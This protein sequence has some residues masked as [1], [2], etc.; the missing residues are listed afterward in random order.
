M[1]SQI[2]LN[3][4][5][6]VMLVLVVTLSVL[7]AVCTVVMSRPI[8]LAASSVQAPTAL[9]SLYH[10]VFYKSYYGTVSTL[11]LHNASVVQSIITFTFSTGSVFTSTTR[12][13]PPHGTL[14]LDSDSTPEVGSGVY[15]LVAGSDQPVESVVHVYRTDTG[16][17]LAAYRGL[18]GSALATTL[19]F[20][21]A[22]DQNRLFVVN[23][24]AAPANMVIQVYRLDGSVAGSIIQVLPPGATYSVL[25]STI[26][27]AGFVGQAVVSA[28]QP[29]TGLMLRQDLTGHQTFEYVPPL[30]AGA[31]VYLPRAL[32][33]V[34]EGGGS[35][36]T[37]LYLWNGGPAPTTATLKYYATTGTL[38]HQ[39]NVTLT[40]SGGIN[41][42]LSTISNLPGGGLWSVTADATQPIGV[43]DAT[44]YDTASNYSLASYGTDGNTASAAQDI[45]LPRIVRN[46]N[47]YTVLSV[48]S[49]PGYTTTLTLIYYDLSGTVVYTDVTW[50]QG[51]GRFNHQLMPQLGAS[52]EGSVS[53]HASQPI[54]AAVDEFVIPQTPTA[55]ASVAIDGPANGLANALYFFHA[56]VNPAAATTPLTYVWRIEGQP[57]VIQVGGLND[58]ALL[59]WPPGAQGVHTITVAASN[60]VGTVTGTHAILLGPPLNPL[61]V[62]SAEPT[63]LDPALVTF[64]DEWRVAR[65]T[66]EGLTRLDENLEPRPALASAWSY[67]PDASVYTFTLREAYFANGRRVVA[68]DVTAS[69]RRALSPTLNGGGPADYASTLFDIQGAAQYNSGLITT[70][71]G[72][73]ALDAAT[74]RFDLVGVTPPAVFLKQ[75]S[76]PIAALIPIEEVNAGGAEWWRN[77]VHYFGAGPY[78]LTEWIS[79]SHISLLINPLYQV[80]NPIQYGGRSVP[81]GVTIYFTATTA[82]LPAFRADRAGCGRSYCRG[83]DHGDGRSAPCQQSDQRAGNL[84]DLVGDG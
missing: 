13:I 2:Q 23:A 32:K 8:A 15:A 12:L 56:A 63:M 51:W 77:P 34:D 76:Q 33:T 44:D 40:A 25:I 66:F 26:A 43:S 30:S 49:M 61:R 11:F 17:K 71:L 45:Y 19:R 1:Q 22:F 20:G 29:V 60:G 72:I 28:D 14:K 65:Q 16:D 58:T 21:P 62:R 35:R 54:G 78:R 82:T 83:H 3:R 67:A 37:T 42:P 81:D 41:L 70:S 57:A 9:Y 79:G 5:L 84:H 48:Q 68:D 75:L 39:M 7:A 73:H 31:S 18:S 24:G 52:F 69:F 36:T 4:W 47:R 10:P 55:P 74:V 6:V 38:A 64:I 27:G 80:G 59:A 46:A 53:I 50:I